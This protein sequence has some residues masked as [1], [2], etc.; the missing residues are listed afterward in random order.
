[1]I[2]FIINPAAGNGKTA[3]AWPRLEQKLRAKLGALKGH[4]TQ[5]P[6]DAD[7]IID[8][9]QRSHSGELNIV[10]VGGDG[11]HHEVINGIYNVL[12]PDQLQRVRYALL[13]FGSGNDWVKTHRIPRRIDAW[14]RMYQHGYK[15]SHN[16]GQ[17]DYQDFSGQAASCIFT[18]VAGMAYDAYVVQQSASTAFKHKLLY[19]L[20]TLAYLRDYRPPKLELQFDGQ[21]V[22]QRFHTINVGISKYNGGGMRLV[23]Q[24]DPFGD[25]LALTYAPRLSIPT[26]LVNGWRFYTST[27]GRV[28]GVVCTQAKKIN[29]SAP[30]RSEDLLIEADGE[31]LGYGPVRIALLPTKLAVIVPARN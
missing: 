20:L 14:I 5:S 21:Q 1:M 8:A 26:I 7:R 24:A 22:Q 10:A 31:L 30:D 28:K 6:K 17:I 12:G 15:R 16:L 3:R 25:Q 13:P 29:I 11:T 18:N 9:I 27:I 23:P 4:Y 2:H 19:P